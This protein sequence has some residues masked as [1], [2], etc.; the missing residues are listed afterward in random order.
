MD[1]SD[2]LKGM[3]AKPCAFLSYNRKNNTNPNSTITAL[4]QY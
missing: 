3:F 1:C 2:F 4:N